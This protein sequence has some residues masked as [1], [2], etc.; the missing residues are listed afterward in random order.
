MRMCMV[1]LC[2]NSLYGGDLQPALTTWHVR[3]AVCRPNMDRPNMHRP[4]MHIHMPTSTYICACHAHVHLHVHWTDTCTCHNMDLHLGMQV[5]SGLD[6]QMGRCAHQL[7][8]AH[9]KD[10]HGKL[11]FSSIINRLK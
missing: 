7:Y 9:Q 1:G 8:E 4:N 2:M 3:M 11:D 6:V 5:A 10:G